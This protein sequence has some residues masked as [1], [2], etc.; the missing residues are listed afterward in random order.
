M[1]IVYMSKG[2]MQGNI[3]LMGFVCELHYVG[4]TFFGFTL[5]WV[6]F[7]FSDII[8]IIIIIIFNIPLLLFHM[9]IFLC[10]DPSTCYP[11]PCLFISSIYYLAYPFMF[12]SLFA[13]HL[14]LVVLLFYIYYINVL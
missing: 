3:P 5:C 12:Y 13:S 6:Y 10:F 11:F 4:F 9:Y 2:K 8:I 1:H 7:F 14:V